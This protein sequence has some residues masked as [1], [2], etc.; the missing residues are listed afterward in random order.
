[1]T[2]LG[3]PVVPE[4]YSQQAGESAPV[5]ATGA[6]SRRSKSP[7]AMDGH[8]GPVR[9]D[10]H[11]VAQDHRGAQLWSGLGDHRKVAGVVGGD[12]HHARAGVVHD[13]GQVVGREHGRQ[14]DRDDARAQRAEEPGHEG[15][16]VVDHHGHPLAGADVE[17]A[18]CVLRPPD[19]LLHVGVGESLLAADQRECGSPPPVATLRSSSHS[20]ALYLVV[21]A[22][23]DQALTYVVVDR[24]LVD[25]GGRRGDPARH[26]AR[27]GDALHERD[28]VGPVGRGGEP[29]ATPRRPLGLGEHRA[30]PG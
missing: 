5:V 3:S 4:L 28:D 14:R 11:V 7:Q 15:R 21:P 2:P 10:R 20:A 30:R 25:A 29:I 24:L 9:R 18:E 13:G 16:L 6:S 1:M 27:L 19:L 22:T 17:R 12:H 8:A 23:A 26:A